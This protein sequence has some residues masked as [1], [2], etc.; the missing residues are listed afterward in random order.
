VSLVV[1]TGAVGVL[2]APS[3][4]DPAA[5]SIAVLCIAL[6][7]GAAGALNMWYDR[8]IDALMRRTSRRAI[9][10]GRIAPQRALVFGLALA[11]LSVLVLG[12]TT[13]VA[14]AAALAGSIAC[15]VLLYTMYLKRRTP[16]NIVWGGAAGALP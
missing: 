10:G 12:L 15:Y 13:N 1:F 11:A 7:A 5:A 3:P 16:Q 14:A 9:P 6:G 4:S 8:D 2:L